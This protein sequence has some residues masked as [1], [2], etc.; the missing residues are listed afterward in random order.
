MPKS[1]SNPGHCLIALIPLNGQFEI[2]KK[3][4]I[5]WFVLDGQVGCWRSSAPA[6][7][8]RMLDQWFACPKD[9][10][11]EN[12]PRKTPIGRTTKAENGTDRLHLWLDRKS[13]SLC[14]IRST[15]VRTLYVYRGQQHIIISQLCALDFFHSRWD[16]CWMYFGVGALPRI[17]IEWITRNDGRGKMVK[18]T[19]FH[20]CYRRIEKL[21]T[22][23]TVKNSHLALQNAHEKRVENGAK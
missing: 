5:N 6:S 17:H 10:V 9:T 22:M 12:L 14:C 8:K 1:W 13:S 2:T 3:G 21:A 16:C 11:G 15:I 23:E 4:V 20:R 19:L 18:F 7:P